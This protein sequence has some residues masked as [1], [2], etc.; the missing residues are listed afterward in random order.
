MIELH[1][2]VVGAG[3]AGLDM[4]HRLRQLGLSARL[5]EAGGNGKGA[6]APVPAE[7]A[8][9]VETWRTRLVEAVA[10]S[11]EALLERFFEEGRLSDEE[12]VRG[13][14]AAVGR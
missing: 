9:A 1:A 13:L 2:V 4:L 5:F 11:D 8:A 3:F 14:R 6:D 7:L 12:L 10:E